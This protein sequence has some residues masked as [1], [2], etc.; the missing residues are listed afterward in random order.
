MNKRIITAIPTL[1]VSSALLFVGINFAIVFGQN[2]SSDQNQTAATITGQPQTTTINKTAIPAQ[3]T[4]VTVNQTTEPIQG[5][6]LHPLQN[7]TVQ[8]TPSLAGIENQTTVQA[9]GP[10]T[11]TVVNKTTVPFNHTILETEVNDTSDAKASNTSGSQNQSQ[12]Q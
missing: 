4:T 10:A 3:Q 9:T 1:A 11:T 7:Q 2:Q 5:Q 6:Q 12:P 8:Q